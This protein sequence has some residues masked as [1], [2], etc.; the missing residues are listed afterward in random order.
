MESCKIK[1]RG[2]S[3]I[4]ADSSRK[5]I[6]EQLVNILFGPPAYCDGVPIP[7][8]WL[9]LLLAFCPTG[10]HDTGGGAFP[11]PHRPEGALPTGLHALPAPLAS[12][13]RGMRAG[14]S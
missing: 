1:I 14:D 11:P 8:P 7:R 13:P 2:T 6:V 3:E 10:L 4:F 5:K 9:Q 12:S